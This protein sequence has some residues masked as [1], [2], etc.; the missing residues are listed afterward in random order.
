MTKAK[1]NLIRMTDL[2][3]KADLPR[4]TLKFYFEQ[5]LLLPQKKTEGGYRL[6]DEREGLKRLNEIK[7]LR[8]KRRWTIGEIKLHFK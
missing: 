7:Q 1:N 6:F 5:G 4:S 8:E 2:A 3:K